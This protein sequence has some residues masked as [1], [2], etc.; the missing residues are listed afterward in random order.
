M[1]KLSQSNR[2]AL[3]RKARKDQKKKR[4]RKTSLSLRQSAQ[5]LSGDEINFNDE[6][7]YILE[8]ASKGISKLISLD[9][10][11]LF[12]T[13]DG[14][15]WMIDSAD[16]GAHCLMKCFERQPYA[17]LE[18]DDGFYVKWDY[19]YRIEDDKFIVFS[20][21]IVAEFYNY[22]TREIQKRIEMING[23]SWWLDN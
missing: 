17:A 13:D 23:P 7:E 18:T 22:P 3:Q 8:S 9:K 10:L 11:I 2:A 6:I 12:C 16:D 19:L 1:K 21:A 4:K 15:A 14:D 5:I 20:D